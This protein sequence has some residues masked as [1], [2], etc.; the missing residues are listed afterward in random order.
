MKILFALSEVRRVR[1]INGTYL[2]LAPKKVTIG[3]RLCFS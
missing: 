2:K 3:F 1:K